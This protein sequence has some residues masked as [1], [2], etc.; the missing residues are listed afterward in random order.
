MS[1]VLRKPRPFSTMAGTKAD[2]MTVEDNTIKH[3]H[4][5]T[6]QTGYGVKYIAYYTSTIILFKNKDLNQLFLKWEPLG[7]CE[8]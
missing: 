8:T 4:R 7:V 1:W 3:F 6:R 5:L 2:F